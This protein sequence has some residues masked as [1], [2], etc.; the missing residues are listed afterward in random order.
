MISS[1]LRKYAV[2]T[3]VLAG[4][5]GLGL[6]T[7]VVTVGAPSSPEGTFISAIERWSGHDVVDEEWLEVGTTIC[8]STTTASNATRTLL[9]A[10]YGLVNDADVVWQAVGVLCPQNAVFLDEAMAALYAG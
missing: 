9:S 4:V 7:G 2:I 5:L 6:A 3:A 8:E 1:L 10:D